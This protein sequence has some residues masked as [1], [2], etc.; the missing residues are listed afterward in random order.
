MQESWRSHGVASLRK[1]I[2]LLESRERAC[3]LLSERGL[4]LTPELITAV[5]AQRDEHAQQALI[6]SLAAG[7]PGRAMGALAYRSA[8]KPFVSLP[9]SAAP[10]PVSSKRA[11]SGPSDATQDLLLSLGRARLK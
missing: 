8:P 11:K 5:A 6:E 3:L 1:R 10:L 7:P 2:R 9:R 4:T